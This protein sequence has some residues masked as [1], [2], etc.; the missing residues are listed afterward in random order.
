M[1]T[2]C[3]YS[4]PCWSMR[5]GRWLAAGASDARWCWGVGVGVRQCNWMA[6]QST[7]TA[8]SMDSMHCWS[9][10]DGRRSA[11]RV[12]DTRR[13]C[14]VGVCVTAPTCTP[15]YSRSCYSHSQICRIISAFLHRHDDIKSQQKTVKHSQQNAGKFIK[16]YLLVNFTANSETQL[17]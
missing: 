7:H 4:T 12:I 13:C 6:P 5:E 16:T 14:G 9:V 1:G 11:A 3:T 2:L 10:R 8:H 15:S 17:F